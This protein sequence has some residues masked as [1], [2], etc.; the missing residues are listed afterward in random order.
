MLAINS[1]GSGMF[2]T[3]TGSEGTGGASCPDKHGSESEDGVAPRGLD[4]VTE[5]ENVSERKKQIKIR[6]PIS[7]YQ[8]PSIG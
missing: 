4:R 7:V 2:E 3:R 1:S 5:S 6:V 8:R